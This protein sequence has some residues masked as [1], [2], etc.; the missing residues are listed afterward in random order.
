M[1]L[2]ALDSR[3]QDATIQAAM[4]EVLN[5]FIDSMATNDYNQLVYYLQPNGKTADVIT[6]H[7]TTSFTRPT[8]TFAMPVEGLKYVFPQPDSVYNSY[9]D[10]MVYYRFPK[11]G[12][13]CIQTKNLEPY[14]LQR[15][16]TLIY[17]TPERKVKNGHYGHYIADKKW[18]GF[19][20]FSYAWF[21]PE[22]FELLYYKCNRP[23]KWRKEGNM[24][25][26]VASANQNDILFEIAYKPTVKIPEVINGRKVNYTKTFDIASP[27][28]TIKA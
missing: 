18:D 26:F 15:G 27:D 24:I 22:N 17:K 2:G 9:T 5:E 21:I 11:G 14:L 10:S 12:Y 13:T 20:Q 28:I 8:V 23:G 7:K 3:A 1:L 19:R 25:H 6:S 4:K 16:D